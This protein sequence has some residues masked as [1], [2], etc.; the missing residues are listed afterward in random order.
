M[1]D[2][3]SQFGYSFQTKLIA[4]LL[5]DKEFLEQVSDVI[6]TEYFDSESNQ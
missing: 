5:L 3:L 2:T 1:A 6:K 4:S